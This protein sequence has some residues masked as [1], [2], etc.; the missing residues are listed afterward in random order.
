M[1]LTGGQDHGGRSNRSGERTHP[2]FIHA[3]HTLHTRRPEGD[4]VPEQLAEPLAFGPVVKPAPRDRSQY[5]PGTRARV[6]LEGGPGRCIERAALDDVA[7]PDVGKAKPFHRLHSTQTAEGHNYAGCLQAR[8]KV[9]H[10]RDLIP[11]IQ[12]GGIQTGLELVLEREVQTGSQQGKDRSF[13]RSQRSQALAQLLFEPVLDLERQRA[14][15]VGRDDLRM[16]VALAAD[17]RRVA[18]PGSDLLDGGA[19]VALGAGLRDKKDGCIK[20]M[21]L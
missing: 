17:G 21:K 9:A 19:D 14:F 4:L 12:S 13:F 7:Q 16:D 2:C 10:D 6:G 8:R 3:S 1:R 20:V 18:E 11:K 5:R 15:D